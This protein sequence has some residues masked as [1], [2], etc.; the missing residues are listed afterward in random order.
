[1]APTAP[2]ENSVPENQ[3]SGQSCFIAFGFLAIA[4]HVRDLLGGRRSHRLANRLQWRVPVHPC[5]PVQ[6]HWEHCLEA[7][8][9]SPLSHRR[10]LFP[11]QSFTRSRRIHV[12]VGYLF[13]CRGLGGPGGLLPESR[14]DRV[15]LDSF[16]RNRHFD[17][18]SD[19]LAAMAIEFTVGDRDVGG[20]QH[21]SDRHDAP[22]A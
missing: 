20:Y 7:A 2:A 12:C 11:H 4:L 22:H 13:C 15:R 9:S 17:S 8:G 14:R 16:R 3:S 19:G 10:A 21:D 1:M 18:R 6:R 5:L